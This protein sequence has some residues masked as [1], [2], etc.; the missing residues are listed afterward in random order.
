MPSHSR[1]STNDE[2]GNHATS[3]REDQ[4]YFVNA[5]GAA[6]EY[7]AE[8]AV[9]APSSENGVEGSRKGQPSILHRFRHDKSILVLTIAGGL[10]YAGTQGGEI[11]VSPWPCLILPTISDLASGLLPWHVRTPKSSPGT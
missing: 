1:N 8:V 2:C 3:F 10:V 5:S 6:N 9:P 7:I 11:L 4:D